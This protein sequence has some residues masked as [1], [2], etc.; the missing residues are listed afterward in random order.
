MNRYRKRPSASIK[1]IMERRKPQYG[2]A[3][4]NVAKT[5]GG[6][7]SHFCGVDGMYQAFS[8]NDVT[9]CCS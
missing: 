9:C 5:R 6:G 4:V 8:I 3:R 2:H 7:S 1:R